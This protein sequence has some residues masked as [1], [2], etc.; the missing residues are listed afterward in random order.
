MK[1]S[2][3]FIDSLINPKKLAAYRIMPIGKVIQY[4]FLLITFV[5]VFSF[6][7]F[8]SGVTEDL[9][10]ID[11][12]TEY[13]ADIQWLLYPFAFIFLFVMTSLLVFIRISL[14]AL[15]GLLLVKS[16][17]RRGEYRQ[18][19]R[20]AAF[21]ITWSTILSVVFTIILIPS[22]VPTLIGVFITMVLLIIALTKYPKLPQK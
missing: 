19:W 5:T 18:I 11:G 1:H 21:A 20:T 22:S 3:L 14:Y 16:I 2:Q 7:R 12:L 17:K 8:S 15:A 13:I 10:N 4:V 9:F 6:G